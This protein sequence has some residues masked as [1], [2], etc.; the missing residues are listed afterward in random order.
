MATVSKAHFIIVTCNSEMKKYIRDFQMLPIRHLFTKT[1]VTSQS[2][3]A[4][5]SHSVQARIQS[6]NSREAKRD[7]IA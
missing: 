6:R 2:R 5:Q 4:I 3:G 1:V 7:T